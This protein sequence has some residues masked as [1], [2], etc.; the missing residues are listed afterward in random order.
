MIDPDGHGEEG[1]LFRSSPKSPVGVSQV[2]QR[3]GEL[4]VVVP[5]IGGIRL[6]YYQDERASLV[7]EMPSLLRVPNTVLEDPEIPLGIPQVNQ[8]LGD[9]RKVHEL[10]GID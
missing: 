1:L 7:E 2:H 8:R 3:V 4:G 6:Q 5:A 9:L 10:L